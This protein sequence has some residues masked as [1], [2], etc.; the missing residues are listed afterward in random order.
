L[1]A[2]RSAPGR[3]HLDHGLHRCITLSKSAELRKLQ[4][5]IGYA[6]TNDWYI[7]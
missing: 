5:K 3:D 7:T 6:F 1:A 4:M 2:Q